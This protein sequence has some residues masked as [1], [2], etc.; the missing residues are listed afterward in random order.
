MIA[1]PP[2][3]W[4]LLVP[5]L[6][7]V[8]TSACT[9]SPTGRRQ[10]QLLSDEQLAE[11]GALAFAEMKEQVPT[12][13]DRGAERY[14]RCVTDAVLGALPESARRSWEVALFEE[15]TPN[16]FALPG[17][18][19]GVHTG[20]LQVASNQGQLAT[21]LGHEVAHVI[22][23]HSNE[24]ASREIATAGVIGV[25]GVVAGE[26]AGQIAGAGAQLGLLLPF[27]RTQE[28]EADVI[29]LVYMSDAGFDPRESVALW[30]NMEKAGGGSPPQFLSTHPSGGTRI[31]DLEARMPE[32]L[33]RWR[34]AR[35]SGRRPAC[36]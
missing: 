23:G 19:I 17:G 2:M 15:P 11:Q 9:T 36:E 13:R 26:G 21:V 34:A 4:S 28:S 10:L 33:E 12:S 22:A 14:V 6:L 27:S 1:S 24:R 16:A 31:K 20:L 8:L 32:A 35:S 29:G 18:K 7:A 25:I 3:R 30:R 5:A